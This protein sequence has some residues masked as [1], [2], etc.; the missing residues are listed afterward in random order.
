MLDVFLFFFPALGFVR[1]EYSSI[2]LIYTLFLV[3][4]N[5]DLLNHS[6]ADY[7]EGS[8]PCNC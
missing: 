2:L 5:R 7:Y 1:Y 4:T 8:D 3:V 6:H